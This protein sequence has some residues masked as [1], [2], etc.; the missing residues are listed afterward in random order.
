MIEIIF[1]QKQG[2]D[3]Y[4]LCRRKYFCAQHANFFLKFFLQKKE[5]YLN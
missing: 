5:S 4:N 3:L 1:R 2:S